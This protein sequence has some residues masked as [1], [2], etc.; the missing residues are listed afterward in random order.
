[1]GKKEK[2]FS[3]EENTMIYQLLNDSDVKKIT[4]GRLNWE[5]QWIMMKPQKR[6]PLASRNGEEARV[7]KTSV[8]FNIERTESL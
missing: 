2:I 8:I 7:N 3:V 5:E 4:V 6:L 1:L